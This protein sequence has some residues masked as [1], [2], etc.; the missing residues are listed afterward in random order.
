MPDIVLKLGEEFTR[1]GFMCHEA[2]T[3]EFNEGA[4]DEHKQASCRGCVDLSLVQP[5]SNQGA[6]LG[7]RLALIGFIGGEHDERGVVS[8]LGDEAC[9]TLT[10]LL[11]LRAWRE[12]YREALPDMLIKGLMCDAEDLISELTLGFKVAVHR[13][14]GCIGELQNLR[15]AGT[16]DA[17]LGKKHGGSFYNIVSFCR[18]STVTGTTIPI[19]RAP[20]HV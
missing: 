4:M 6:K 16:M 11:E 3:R 5:P 18:H 1:R 8:V 13:P 12:V 17:L 14:C 10:Y 7:V 15:H 19:K 2:L 20:I 9:V